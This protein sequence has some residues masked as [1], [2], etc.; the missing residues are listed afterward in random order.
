MSDGESAVQYAVAESRR[1]SRYMV[2]KRLSQEIDSSVVE[3]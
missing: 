2:P 1:V 3:R